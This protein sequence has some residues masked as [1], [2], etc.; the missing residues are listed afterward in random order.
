M[1]KLIRVLVVA[2]FLLIMLA[3]GCVKIITT[4]NTIQTEPTTLYNT[5]GINST[6]AKAANGLSLSVSTDQTDYA[7][8]QEVQIVTDEKNTLAKTNNV[9]IADNWP[10][11]ELVQMYFGPCVSRDIPYGIAVYQGDYTSSNYSTATPLNLYNPTSIFLCQPQTTP[12]PTSFL[13][14]PLS[15]IADIIAGNAKPGGDTGVITSQ[16]QISGQMTLKGYWTGDSVPKFTYFNPGVYTVLGGD[17]WGNLALV[18]FTVSDSVTTDTT[19]VNPEN[20]SV[21]VIA[22]NTND[23]NGTTDYPTVELTLE[24]VSTEPFVSLSAV[25]IEFAP[26]DY[27]FDLNV[28]PENP[29]LPGTNVIGFADLLQGAFGDG[30]AYSLK[31]SGTYQNGQTF[32]FIWEPASN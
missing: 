7:P 17:E 12:V 14:E 10:V 6:S 9:P 27:S 31:I 19:N 25:L 24:N 23:V 16:Q 26:Q 21:K 32:S 8:G 13:F 29:L 5:I 30:I 15:D 2:L 11:N 4:Q 28:T 3:S 22:I 1:K 18:H 20:A